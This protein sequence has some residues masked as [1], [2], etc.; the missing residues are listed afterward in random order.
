MVT[1]GVSEWLAPDMP[2]GQTENVRYLAVR[3]AEDGSTYTLVY[4]CGWQYTISRSG[5]GPHTVL[6]GTAVKTYQQALERMTAGMPAVAPAVLYTVLSPG[7]AVMGRYPLLSFARHMARALGGFVM[8]PCGVCKHD[9]LDVSL[10]G[11]VL[12]WHHESSAQPSA[13]DTNDI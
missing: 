8:G 4:Q 7:D 1:S 13:T 12:C 5:E 9:A 2:H 11:E 10:Q 3:L 6:L